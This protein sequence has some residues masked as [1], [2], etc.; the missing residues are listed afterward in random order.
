MKMSG[1]T[2]CIMFFD[3]HTATLAPYY[4]VLYK[5]NY[6]INKCNISI[7]RLL[8]VNKNSQRKIK[9]IFLFSERNYTGKVDVI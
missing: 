2:C 9:H 1:P 3:L 5:Y 6:L 8:V 7:E 4:P